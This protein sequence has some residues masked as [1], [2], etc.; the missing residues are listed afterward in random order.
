MDRNSSS[1]GKGLALPPPSRFY[2]SH[3]CAAP[4]VHLL[5]T[6]CTMYLIPG[7]PVFCTRC[8]VPCTAAITVTLVPGNQWS[9]NL[10]PVK[11]VLAP[12][13]CSRAAQD[14]RV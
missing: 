10:P 14:L 4:G 8:Q 13:L 7:V 12:T 3:L 5:H 9:L 6:R 2:V 1:I 11:Y